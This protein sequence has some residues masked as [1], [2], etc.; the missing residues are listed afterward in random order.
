M[1]PLP[2]RTSATSFLACLLGLGE[3]LIPFF[4]VVYSQYRY[5]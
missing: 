1:I 5:F 2:M 4:I 3:T